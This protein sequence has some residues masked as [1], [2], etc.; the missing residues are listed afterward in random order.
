[1]RGVGADQPRLAERWVGQQVAADVSGRQ[2]ERP[3]AGNGDVREVLAHTAAIFENP[4]ERRRHRSR[5]AVEREVRVHLP[6][7]RDGGCELAEG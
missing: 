1:M 7:Q 2:P 4:A 6:D 5:A 3:Q